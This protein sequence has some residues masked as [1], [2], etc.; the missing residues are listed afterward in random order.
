[1]PARHATSAPREPRRSA[2][3]PNLIARLRYRLDL[4][5]SRG[6]LMV[7]GYLAVITLAITVA[8]AGIVTGLH[9]SGVSGGPKLGFAESFW[10]S[11]LRMLGRGAFASDQQWATRVVSLIVTLA[12]IFLAGALIALI[13]ASVNQR[14]SRLRKGRSAVLESGHT[15][16]LGW[17]PRLPVILSELVI[18]NANHRRA[19]FVILAERPKDEMEDE[20]RRLVPH[21][22]TT[23]VVCRTGD[24]SKPADLALVNVTGARSVIVL[25]DEEGDAGVV[26][27][28]LA[29]RSLDPNFDRTRLVAELGSASHAETLRSLTDERI[30][31]VQ[32]D[33]VISQVTAQACHQN[34]LA[35]VF[36]D[37]LG[38][39][40]DDIYIKPVPQ[41]AGHTYA[42]VQV[43][44]DTSSIIGVCRDGAITLNPPDDYVF[45]D[46]DEV[47]AISD[48]DDTV[49]LTGFGTQVEVEV[50]ADVAFTEPAQHIAIVGWSP[51][52]AEVIRELDQVLGDGSA[53][54]LL[55]DGHHVDAE[56]VQLPNLAHCT[57]NVRALP[58]GPEALIDVITACEYD[59]A[60]VLGYR[61]RMHAS[62]ADARTMLTLLAMHKA[63]TGRAHR[64]RVVA[65]MLDRANVEIAQTIEVD[66]FIV[67]DELSS[68]MLAQVS[69]RLELHRVFAELF[70]AEGS[71]ISL[72]PAELYAPTHT[73]SYASVVAAAARRGES[74][75]GYRIGRRAVTL[76]PAK[77]T[78][79]TLGPGDQV[80]VLGERTARPTAATVF[81]ARVV[82]QHSLNGATLT[83]AISDAPD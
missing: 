68:L 7:I 10:Q 49:L 16:V 66:D 26:K 36:R 28:V 46:E 67:S 27:T 8:A 53:I 43:A 34:G 29:V 59:Q 80:L 33:Q 31:T 24:P 20:L 40:G 60:I 50:G 55:I 74:A 2:G 4:A 64:P 44:F 23:R 21:T 19:A 22:R 79:I 65:E 18:A 57:I 25:A 72:R 71:F 42:E 54:D 58:H 77:S 1:M 75:I 38:F 13:A 76:N 35:G 83:A 9:L 12:G 61:H 62:K 15:L 41:L 11:M 78:R 45:A 48:D 17:S 51:L 70:D 81:P 82:S 56:E 30:A 39:D 14:V 5:L 32:A 52:G 6:S 3:T 73:I 69:E 47:I 37:L 63:W